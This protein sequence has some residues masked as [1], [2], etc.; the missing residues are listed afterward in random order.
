MEP[1]HH[2]ASGAGDGPDHRGGR[3]AG[4]RAGLW[5]GATPITNRL[6][7]EADGVTVR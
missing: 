1:Q 4:S 7:I 5:A 3:S 6:Y 2:L